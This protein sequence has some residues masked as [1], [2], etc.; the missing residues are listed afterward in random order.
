MMGFVL[1][2]LDRYVIDVGCW[3][4]M[5]Q[6]ADPRECALFKNNNFS[7]PVKEWLYTVRVF[8]WLS[9]SVRC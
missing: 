9:F 3:L 6:L 5:G 7:R 2:F 8:V 1:L 4:A